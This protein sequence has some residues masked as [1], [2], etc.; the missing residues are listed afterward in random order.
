MKVR[1]HMTRF[2]RPGEAVKI[3]EIDIPDDM[4]PAPGPA[5]VEDLLELAFM[6]GQNDM[7]RR[8]CPSL[9]GGDVIELPELGLFRAN[10]VMGFTKVGPEALTVIGLD[11]MDASMKNESEPDS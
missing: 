3:R 4:L 8:E 11:A 10:F 7:Q 1:A 6:W 2:A 9:S 5:F